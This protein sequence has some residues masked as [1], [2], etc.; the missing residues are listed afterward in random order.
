ML[1]QCHSVVSSVYD[2]FVNCTMQSWSYDRHNY[3][4]IISIA[5]AEIIEVILLS[6]M[7]D[8]DGTVDSQFYDE[9]HQS[10]C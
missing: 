10:C 9:V 2:S 5:I 4:A 6:Y 1:K 3:C 8:K 7:N